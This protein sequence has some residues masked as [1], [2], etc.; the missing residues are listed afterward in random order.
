MIHGWC[1]KAGEGVKYEFEEV[2][3]DVLNV[4]DKNFQ[5]LALNSTSNVFDAFYKCVSVLNAFKKNKMEN[6]SSKFF[7]AFITDNVQGNVVFHGFRR[8]WSK[9]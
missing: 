4:V 7:P 9:L 5:A 8:E 3:L 1:K 2:D 6:R